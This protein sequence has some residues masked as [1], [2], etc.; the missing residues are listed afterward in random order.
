MRAM[1]DST[2]LVAASRGPAVGRRSCWC[3]PAVFGPGLSMNRHSPSATDRTRPLH[4][5]VLPHERLEI[6]VVVDGRVLARRHRVSNRPVVL[7]IFRV[8]EA[9]PRRLRLV[10]LRREVAKEFLHP[11]RLV[12]DGSRAVLRDLDDLHPPHE[13]SGGR[14]AVSPRIA[15]NSGCWRDL[16]PGGSLSSAESYPGHRRSW[17]DCLVRVIRTDVVVAC[18][19]SFRPGRRAP[20]RWCVPG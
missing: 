9:S 10:V 2:L 5:V 1:W 19:C 6:V 15:L 11:V 16:L 13:K 14:L 8:T 3:H 12:R 18:G 4:A 17:E 7:H 20:R